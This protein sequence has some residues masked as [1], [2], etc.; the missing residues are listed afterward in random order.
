MD[1]NRR[2]FLKLAGLGATATGLGA[3]PV[4]TG[5]S[6]KANAGALKNVVVIGGGF[7]GTTVAKYLLLS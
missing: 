6:N 4:L 3:L 2:N 5:L 1:S 7:G